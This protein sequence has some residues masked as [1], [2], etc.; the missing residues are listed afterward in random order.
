MDWRY[1]S[2]LSFDYEI[3]WF[4]KNIRDGSLKLDPEQ[5]KTILRVHAMWLH[6]VHLILEDPNCPDDESGMET[7]QF[8]HPYWEKICK[9]AQYALSLI[10]K[11][12]GEDENLKP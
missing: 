3:S 8:N 6:F 5:I 2:A 10:E 12:P 1:E 11:D 9:Q 4:K 7:Y